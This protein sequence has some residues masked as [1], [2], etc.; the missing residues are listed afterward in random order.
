MA[1]EYSS[2][3]QVVSANQP[4]V[5]TNAPVPC[6]EGIIFHRD[7]TGIFLLS[8]RGLRPYCQCCGVVVPQALYEVAFHADVQIPEGGE[9]GT[10]TLALVVDGE[11]EPAAVMSVTPAAVEEPFNIGT[12]SI[13]NVPAICGCSR[14][15]VRNIGDADVE[16]LSA[17]IIFNRAGVQR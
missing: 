1:A 15:S 4:V 12:A 10:I 14:V 17:N 8:S 3:D 7:G 11:V 2:V 13:V 5:F 6:N 16:V 9:V